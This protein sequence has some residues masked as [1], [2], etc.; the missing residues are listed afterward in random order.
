MRV[1]FPVPD[2]AMKATALT[3][4]VRFL[5][6]TMIFLLGVDA[7]EDSTEIRRGRQFGLH[8]MADPDTRKEV[9]DPIVSRFQEIMNR[10]KAT[11]RVEREERLRMLSRHRD[12]GV[13]SA[14]QSKH[15]GQDFRAGEGEIARG[16]EDIRGVR[17]METGVQPP[18][19]APRINVRQ[20]R[21]AIG[22]ESFRTISDEDYLLKVLF[23][24][25]EH[26]FEDWGSS[27][28]QESLIPPHPGTAPTYQ[29]DAADIAV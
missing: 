6:E 26:G 2:R 7:P 27:E 20:D 29:E 23:Q 15:I 18:Q 22:R 10:L 3:V 8:D 14:S 13:V 4:I 21:E 19:R 12:D 24:D 25:M 9:I 11:L 16:R 5:Q 17:R 28:R 1:V